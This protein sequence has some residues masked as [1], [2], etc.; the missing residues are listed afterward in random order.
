[1]VQNIQVAD[2]SVLKAFE[3]VDLD[4]SV[5]QYIEWATTYMDTIGACFIY[6]YQNVKP[7]TFAV[8]GKV[9]GSCLVEALFT[10]SP[11]ITYNITS[12]YDNTVLGTLDQ[13]HDCVED[14]CSPVTLNP[15][16]A[17]IGVSGL[18]QEELI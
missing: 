4:T 14:T 18:P 2:R 6:L 16:L 12:F 17:G 8:D 13:L 1:M 3:E 11:N 15:D 10:Y 5:P 7:Y 9:L